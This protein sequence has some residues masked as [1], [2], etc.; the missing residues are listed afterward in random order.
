M[1][2][3]LGANGC[4]YVE[5][6]MGVKHLLSNTHEAKFLD[7]VFKFYRKSQM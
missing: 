3:Q 2:F 5:C 1:V 6:G 4:G 7:F